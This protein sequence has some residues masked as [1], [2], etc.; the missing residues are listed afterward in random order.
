MRLNSLHLVNFR[1]HADTRITFDSGLTGIIGPNGSGKTTILE[2][3]TWA[4]YGYARGT[5]DSIRNARA[6]PR[7]PVRVELDFELGQHRYRVERGLNNAELYLDN[8]A[9]PI[10]NT[11]SSVTSQLQKKL[12]MTR[13]EFFNT[14]FTG[15][16][17]LGLMAAMGPSDRARFLSRV[18]GYERLRV[19]QEMA[20]ER[21]KAILAEVTGMRS[22]MGDRE[23]IVRAVTAAELR[24][25]DATERSVQASASHDRAQL[26]LG[27]IAPQWERVQ[28]ERE[29]W[30]ELSVRIQVAEAK[31]EDHLKNAQ[32]IARD[33]DDVRA[34]RTE[35]DGLRL[36]LTGYRALVQELQQLD[37]L[38][39]EEGRRKAL[40]EQERLLA[41]E[42]KGL[43]ER[44]ERLEVA[45]KT[46]VEVQRELA[47][48][49]TTFTDA[50]SRAETRQ[51]EWVRDLQEAK[52][53][54][55]SLVAQRKDVR[56]QQDQLAAVGEHGECPTCGQSL[57]GGHYRKVLDELERQADEI[58]VNGKYYQDR[59]KQL[60]E[61]PAD[62]V[63]LE[64]LSATL[65]K[66]VT[67]LETKLVRVQEAVKQLDGV[68]KED[69]EKRARRKKIR[70]ELD[71]LP[72]GY[73]E[74]RHKQARAEVDRLTPVDHRAARMSGAVERTPILEHDK[75]QIEMALAA[76]RVTVAELQGQRDALAF[77][78]AL[79]ASLRE[80]FD[81]AEAQV[82]TT[83]LD[84]V[85]AGAEAQAARKALEAAENARSEWDKIQ[86]RLEGLVVNRRLHD[87]VDRAYSD[88]RNDLN[89]QLRP[90]ISELA[91]V[92]L[93]ELTDGRYSE[94]ELDEEYNINVLE[95]GVP[96]PV[97]SG[98]EEDVANLVLRL[99]VSQM[100]A[101]R[102][103]QAFSLL[104]LDEVFGSLDDS[105]RHNVVELLRRLHD[106]FD[107]VILITHI[108]SV[109]DGL[110]RVITVRY[111]AARGT[112]V[113]DAPSGSSSDVPDLPLELALEA[114]D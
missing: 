87:E 42:L 68:R 89:I 38:A 1:Q 53:K 22:G 11:I 20:R 14:Y 88:L 54:L 65:K 57:G 61:R 112:S 31:V 70:A 105:R 28:A 97:I 55:Q 99:S 66:Q 106:R 46:L 8:G 71:S 29:R 27:A 58:A 39:R 6:G 56:R 36:Q 10:A 96:K 40:V 90:E 85:R 102:A 7:A 100:I 3:I 110:D 21:R 52:T 79:H 45:P 43:E 94:L 18:L 12:G 103:G 77:D 25:G 59:Q 13:A 23:T 113:V 64:A 108:D 33:L 107:Q 74:A 50:Q 114:A 111:D 49:Q 75:A 98:G 80:Q 81:R 83:E 17:E 93:N 30:Q 15:Q 35:L 2:A 109:R 67:A 82:R 63:E 76:A 47:A 9:N 41:E 34:A 37:V 48:A 44:V 95:D 69:T 5:R 78:V 62:L 73:D 92:F 86:A 84:A 19:A 101:D 4:L 26:A 91:S 60:T 72:T 16:K 24:L 32:R 104:V 51:N